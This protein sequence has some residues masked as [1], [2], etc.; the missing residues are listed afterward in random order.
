[1]LAPAC[2]NSSSTEP[3]FRLLYLGKDLK[4][5][6]ALRQL[7]PAPVYLL[8]T[9]SDPESAVLFH[10]SDIPYEVLL[11]DL[12]W[13]GKDGLEIARLARKLRHRKRMPIVLLGNKLSRHTKANAA[14]AGVSKCLL[15]KGEFGEV[16]KR[17]TSAD[18]AD[19][20]D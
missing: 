8:V 7:L 14:K 17:L 5:M 18:Y 20:A 1:M 10:K 4:L 13:R 19:S 16:I 9:C 2:Q 6:A 15:K 3:E 11:I 12:E